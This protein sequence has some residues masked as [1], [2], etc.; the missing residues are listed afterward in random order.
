MEGK[1]DSS[2]TSVPTYQTTRC[3]FHKPTVLIYITMRTTQ[4]MNLI[5]ARVGTKVTS[6]LREGQNEI[7]RLYRNWFFQQEL[8]M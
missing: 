4:L 2:K 7:Y 1:K 5:S 8:Y 3:M 6:V